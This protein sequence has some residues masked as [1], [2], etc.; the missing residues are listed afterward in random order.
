MGLKPWALFCPFV[1]ASYLARKK[2]LTLPLRIAIDGASRDAN[3]DWVKTET[4]Q[5]CSDS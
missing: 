2:R 1:E 3:S 5:V 4:W